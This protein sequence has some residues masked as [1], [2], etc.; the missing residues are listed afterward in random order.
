VLI[1]DERSAAYDIGFHNIKPPVYLSGYWQS[2]K[3]FI[4]IVSVIRSDF[5]FPIYGITPENMTIIDAV[6][7][8]MSVSIHVRRGDYVSSSAASERH[9]ICPPFYYQRGMEIMTERLKDVVFYVFSDDTEWAKKNI[10]HKTQPC[11][12]I[13][14]GQR[15]WVDMYIMSQCQHHIIANSSF[16]WWGAWLNPDPEKIVI[17]PKNWFKILPDGFTINDMLP[18]AWIK[19]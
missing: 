17:A 15:S 5:A 13:E 14:T 12:I 7:S 4:D 10:Q 19:I 2:E 9:G 1:Y 11:Y 6:K 18:A 8:S 3:Y 16:S